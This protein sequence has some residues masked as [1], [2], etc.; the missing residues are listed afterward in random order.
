MKAP[1][2]MTLNLTGQLLLST[3]AIGDPRFARSVIYLCTH[4]PEGA[5][6][7]VLN[8]PIPKLR[9]GMVLDQIGIDTGP[10][11]PDAPVLGGGPVEPQRGFVLHR[12]DAGPGP[13]HQALPGG[14]ALS[15]STEVLGAI[16]RGQ[17]PSDWLLALGYAGWG[18]G[19]L[20]TEL[21]QNA[22]LT[23]DADPALVFA[24]ERG[25]ALWTRALRG[26]GIDPLGLSA[27]A[28]RA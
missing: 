21:A 18:A 5:F 1:A 19:Q 17:G 10:E 3:P 16:A 20:E 23:R 13:A 28:G 14:L 4:S 26:M 2:P 24:A 22:W 8:R 7:L 6:G 12:D 11:T 27:Q 9:L 25:E 15:A